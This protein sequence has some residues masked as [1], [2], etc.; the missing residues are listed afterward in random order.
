MFAVGYNMPGYMPEMDI[1]YCETA[2]EAKRCLI[3]MMDMHA[4][5][6]FEVE[7]HNLA[8]E[9]TFAYEDLN[10]CDVSG[11]YSVIICD[12]DRQHDLG[13]HYWIEA[14]VPMEEV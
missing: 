11:G 12:P 4:D 6:A 7:S 10:L 1:C 13:T 3:D 8:N 9:L 2:D 14:N 5:S